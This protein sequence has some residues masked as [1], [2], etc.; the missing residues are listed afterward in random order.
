M[1]KPRIYIA[2]AT[3]YPV[4]G[5]AERQALLQA[6]S[7]RERGYE[8]TIVTFRHW[9]TCLCQETV[10][11]VPTIRIA[12][13]LLGDREKRPRVLQRLLYLLALVIMGWTLWKHRHCYDILHDPISLDFTRPSYA[14]SRY[15]QRVFPITCS[16][17]GISSSSQLYSIFIKMLTD[18]GDVVLDP[19]AGSNTTGAVAESLRRRWLAFDDVEE[20]LSASKFRFEPLPS[21]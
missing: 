10:E 20:Y 19:F 11:G 13:M 15:S 9:K 4:V 3:F 21:G 2:I 7:L 18:E 14:R 5:G 8:A 12:G 17:H 1:G 16:Q 6:R